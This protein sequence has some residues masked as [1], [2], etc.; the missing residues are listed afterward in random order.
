MNAR[1]TTG[2]RVPLQ[3]Q[4][5]ILAPVYYDEPGEEGL[6]PSAKQKRSR[7]SAAC[8]SSYFLYLYIRKMT[9]DL[10]CFM[11]HNGA[12]CRAVAYTPGCRCRCSRSRTSLL[13]HATRAVPLISVT[14][15]SLQLA[16]TIGWFLTTATLCSPGYLD[17]RQITRNSYQ[18]P[19]SVLQDSSFGII[20]LID[21][22]I[23]RTCPSHAIDCFYISMA[24]V[25]KWRA[26]WISRD[27]CH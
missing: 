18:S 22:V 16:A 11:K 1:D 24:R 8:V 2:W 17:P 4:N 10:I 25:W 14:E 7:N 12:S 5:R 19:T 9:T 3:R 23:V 21:V 27:Q 15:N 20:N 26:P 13:D 6:T